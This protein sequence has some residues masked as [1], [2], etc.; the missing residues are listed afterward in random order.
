MQLTG[1]ETVAIG[2]A[3]AIDQ[4]MSGATTTAVSANVLAN[5]FWSVNVS[6]H[7]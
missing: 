1:A 7:S 5:F 2:T 6:L 4:G 3:P